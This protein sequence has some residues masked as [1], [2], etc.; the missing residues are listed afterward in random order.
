MMLLGV[1]CWVFC[2]GSLVSLPIEQQQQQQQKSGISYQHQSTAAEG[3]ARSVPDEKATSDYLKRLAH[4]N[5]K[6][7]TSPAAPAGFEFA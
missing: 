7:G 3:A 4:G 2:R 6:F 1:T 5:R